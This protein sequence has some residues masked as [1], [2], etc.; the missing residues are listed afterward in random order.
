[1]IYTLSDRCLK[2]SETGSVCLIFS[3]SSLG[4]CSGYLTCPSFLWREPPQ[5]NVFWQDPNDEK[6]FW[7]HQ[8]TH[9]VHKW[10]K[11]ILFHHSFSLFSLALLGNQGS[12]FFS[13][14]CEVWHL[15]LRG[16]DFFGGERKGRPGRFCTSTWQ[17]WFRSSKNWEP[18]ILHLIF[19][20]RLENIPLKDVSGEKLPMHF[21][22]WLGSV[23]RF[24]PESP[25]RRF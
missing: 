9:Q 15:G 3:H 17:R 20:F 8:K 5:K 18:K 6:E 10:W 11:R 21:F 24:S 19:S 16:A 13:A 14:K 7:F 22:T 12:V 4:A 1:M 2:L 23:S 25:G